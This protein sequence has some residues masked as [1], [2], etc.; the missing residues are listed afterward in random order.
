M[1]FGN[2]V[3]RLSRLLALAVLVGGDVLGLRTFLALGNFHRYLLPFLESLAAITIYR[4][5]MN[6]HILAVFLLDKTIT[7]LIAEPFDGSGYS[8]CHIKYSLISNY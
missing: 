1:N 7:F 6:K 4:T 5:M 2:R 8:F 3:R